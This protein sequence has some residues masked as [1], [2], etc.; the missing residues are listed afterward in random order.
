MTVEEYEK[1]LEAW[2]RRQVRLVGGEA[3][4][5]VGTP[6]MP[7]RLVILNGK[8]YLVELKRPT[9]KLAPLQQVWHAKASDM[10][11]EVHVLYNRAQCLNWIRE[12]TDEAYYAT[13][14]SNRRRKTTPVD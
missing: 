5:I 14:Q 7:D 11:V 4:K 9:G 2:F 1:H 10:G 12:R 6:G 3:H 13:K 8:L